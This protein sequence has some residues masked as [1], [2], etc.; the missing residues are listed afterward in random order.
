M[1]TK[2]KGKST[3]PPPPPVA[4]RSSGLRGGGYLAKAAERR[5]QEAAVAEIENPVAI[6][7][8]DP[9]MECPP[10]DRFDV[11]DPRA[12]AYLEEHGYVVMKSVA[13]AEQLQHAEQLIFRFM[14]EHAGWKQNDPDSWT[15]EGLMKVSANG[16]ANGLINKRGAGQSDLDWYVRTLPSVRSV[17]EQVWGTA[18]LITSF[19]CFGIFRPWQTGKFFK[20]LGGWFHVDQGTPGKQ[21][22]QGLLSI[23]DQDASTG[24]LTVIPGSHHRFEEHKTPE[25]FEEYIPVV[26]DNS[27]WHGPHRLVQMRAGDFVLWD[28]RTVHCNSPAIETPVTPEDRLLRAVVYV[29]MTPRSYAT[30]DVL[31]KRIEAY[32]F[33]KTTTHWPH[34]H[35]NGFGFKCDPPLQFETAPRERRALI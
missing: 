19:D 24:G 22:I 8:V 26:E 32:N 31:E 17:F 23:F 33:C 28:S 5:K 35:P 10:S 2:G 29:C 13:N 20:T 7:S 12:M 18:D 6:E 15:D 30:P 4:S 27:L 14:G 16:L 3:P 1:V 9:L 25:P 21:C 11:G 34:K